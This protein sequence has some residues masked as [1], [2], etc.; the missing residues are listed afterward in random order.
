M[1]KQG[2]MRLILVVS[3]IACQKNLPETIPETDYVNVET[4]TFWIYEVV[5][6][7]YATGAPESKQ[8]F[9]QRETNLQVVQN[10]GYLLI[11]QTID[12]RTDSTR[13]WVFVGKQTW[14]LYADKLIRQNNEGSFQ[15]LAFPVFKGNEW[16]YVV[17]AASSNAQKIRYDKVGIEY[18]LNGKKYLNCLTTA[19]NNIASAINLRQQTQVY[20]PQIGLVF[21]ENTDLNYCQSSADCVGKKI[22]DFGYQETFTLRAAGKN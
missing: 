21:R 3:P 6:T 7:K 12:T 8:V 5:K 9:Q 22:I 1:I 17:F 15:D 14:K 16:P 10:Q 13:A 18:S 4:G 2:L 20:A 19:G 11:E